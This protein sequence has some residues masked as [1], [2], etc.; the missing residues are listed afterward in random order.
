MFSRDCGIITETIRSID[1]PTQ[2]NSTTI[3]RDSTCRPANLGVPTNAMH[4]L[5]MEARFVATATSLVL[6]ATAALFA[7]AAV[8]QLFLS[9]APIVLCI[10]P[11]IFD[12]RCS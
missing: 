3:L 4:L 2:R 11:P 7:S 10:V 5:L 8:A 1:C 9:F 6:A 12:R